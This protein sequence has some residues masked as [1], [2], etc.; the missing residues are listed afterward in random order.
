VTASPGRR[1]VGKRCERPEHGTQFERWR[2]VRS[3]RTLAL[4]MSKLLRGAVAGVGAWKLGGGIFGTILIFII[5]W[6]LLGNFDI[7]R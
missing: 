2:A 1:R 5:L 7:F 6:V 4:T 3:G